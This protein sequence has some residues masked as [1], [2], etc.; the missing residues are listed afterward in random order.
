[1]E[2]VVGATPEDAARL[3]AQWLAR[4]IRSAV[5]LRGECRIALSGGTTPMR[6]FDILATLAVPWSQVSVFQV[7]ER[8]APDGDPVRN[9]SH[10]IEH[11]FRHVEIRQS[12][13][14]LMPVTDPDLASAAQTYGKAVS[15][16]RLDIVHLGL[17]DDGHTASW[18]PD[19][20]VLNL[21]DP[22]A[23]TGAFN[24]RVR[25]TM[26]R[27]PVNAARCRLVQAC[28]ESKAPRCATGCWGT[29]CRFRRC[30][31]SVR[32][33]SWTLRQLH[34]CRQ[35]RARAG[36][37]GDVEITVTPAW[38]ALADLAGSK[39]VA[40]LRELFA[41]DAHRAA[42]FTLQAVDLRVD[43]SKQRITA[44]TMKRADPAGSC[45]RRRTAPRC[46]VC[47]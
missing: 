43:Y 19:D 41:Q 46:N 30:G 29:P 36:S 8:V 28:G 17:G 3:G 1:M 20:P 27:Q 23:I 10:L 33:R 5:R 9:A 40:P 45:C 39:T 35:A 31:G 21:A 15:I 2:I 12:A 14:F 38:H 16:A 11:L 13:Q 7:D 6:M 26:T 47:R 18:P 24:D 22:V 25:M 4:R 44:A 42:A 37:V 32:P 34:C